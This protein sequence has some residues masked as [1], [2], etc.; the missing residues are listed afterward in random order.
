MV[1]FDNRFS[2]LKAVSEFPLPEFTVPPFS[3]FPSGHGQVP[4]HL[5]LAVS[6]Q[7]RDEK[8]KL[9]CTQPLPVR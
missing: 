1:T 4:A 7:K 5:A 9:C 8:G 2:T 3:G 6:P